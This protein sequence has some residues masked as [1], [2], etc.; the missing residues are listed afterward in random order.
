MPYELRQPGAAPA[1]YE[2]EEAAIA[3]ASAA[4]RGNPDLE[5]EV[6]DLATGQPCAP[7]ASASWREELRRQ[8]GF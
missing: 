6:I 7:G 5:L 8:V 4:L 3:A 2:T 1:T